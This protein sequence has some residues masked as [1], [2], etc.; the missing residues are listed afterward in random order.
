[1]AL[2]SKG[3]MDHKKSGK[4][5]AGNEEKCYNIYFTAE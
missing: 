2:P 1:M 4:L 3:L 5:L